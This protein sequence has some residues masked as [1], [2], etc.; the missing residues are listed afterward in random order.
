[1]RPTYRKMSLLYLGTKMCNP[2]DLHPVHQLWFSV[3]FRSF[4]NQTQV[5]TA[6]DI[7]VFVS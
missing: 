6:K 2:L 5:Q 1:M 7:L 4:H 3:A